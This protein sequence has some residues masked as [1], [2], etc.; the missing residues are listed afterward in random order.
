MRK[1]MT[2]Q[3][4]FTLV[5][6]IAVLILLGILAAVAVP[7]YFDLTTEAENKA[8]DAAVSELNA[9]ENMAWGKI[10]LSAA[11]W[12]DDA[13]VITEVDAA[14]GLGD[15]YSWAA[16]DPDAAGGDLTFGGVTRTLTRSVSTAQT[17]ALWED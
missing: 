12:A 1:R 17:P 11:G 8:L 7:K 10:K 3:E 4:G 13:G 2:Y 9:R 5:E 6:I 14:T 16:G 15:G